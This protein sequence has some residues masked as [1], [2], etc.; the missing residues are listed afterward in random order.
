MH[1]LPEHLKKTSG[2]F[3]E[4]SAKLSETSR[5]IDKTTQELLSLVSDN[6]HFKQC[7]PIVMSILENVPKSGQ[8]LVDAV[9]STNELIESFKEQYEAFDDERFRAALIQFTNDSFSIGDEVARILDKQ[10]Q[11]PSELLISVIEKFP[12]FMLFGASLVIDS[13]PDWDTM[14]G[15]ILETLRKIPSLNQARDKLCETIVAQTEVY[16]AMLTTQILTQLIKGL[17]EC[18]NAIL[19]RDVSVSVGINASIIGEGG[20]GSGGTELL[21][22]PIRLPFN[23]LIFLFKL[24]DLISSKYLD[25]YETCSLNSWQSSVTDQIKNLATKRTKNTI[26]QTPDP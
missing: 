14:P 12:K 15:S 3:S 21:G 11:L 7:I 17:I 4:I 26:S 16:S 19:P 13:I 1:N 6:E 22:H 25:L 2:K 18:L 10:I 23:A 8:L 24:V 5:K 9:K 20:G